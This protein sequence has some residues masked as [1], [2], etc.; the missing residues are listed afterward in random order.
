MPTYDY[1]CDN[2]DWKDNLDSYER[3][4]YKKSNNHWRGI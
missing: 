2:C 4:Q 3:K 1:R